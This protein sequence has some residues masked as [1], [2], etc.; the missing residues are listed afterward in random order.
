MLSD[1]KDFIMS[2]VVS[3]GYF[4]EVVGE[5]GQGGNNYICNTTFNLSLR[6]APISKLAMWHSGL[7]DKFQTD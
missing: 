6:Q 5:E 3:M 7:G 1:G 4:I 2:I